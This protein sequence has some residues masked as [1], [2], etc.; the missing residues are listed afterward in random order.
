MLSNLLDNILGA[1]GGA[2]LHAGPRRLAGWGLVTPELKRPE[3]PRLA[4][5][6][7][8]LLAEL[9]GVVQNPRAWFIVL[10]SNALQSVE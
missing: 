9:D 2:P 10:P 1:R 8:S 6:A 3:R 4:L 7:L 5:G